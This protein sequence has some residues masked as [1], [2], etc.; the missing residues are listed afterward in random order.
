M[1]AFLDSLWF[2]TVDLV[3]QVKNLLDGIFAPLNSLG[4][5]IAI[6]AI[7]LITVL[8]AKCLSKTIK[9]RRYKELGEQF[10]YW[11]NLR[12]EALKNEDP[13]KAK[14]LAKNIDQAKLNR[15]YY[16]YFFEGLMISLVTKV[17]PVLVFLAYVNEAYKP[18]NLL[19]LFGREYVLR[20]KAS[21]GSEILVGAASW[22]VV[23]ILG[24][25]V[26][27]FI[28]KRMYLRYKTAKK[29]KLENEQASSPA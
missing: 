25:Y 20:F 15:A 24:V 11:F 10:F 12:Q 6:L 3:Y 21:G 13:D 9:T 16:D 29:T 5:V 8:I 28:A 1:E 7:A 19:K 4:P 18:S 27:W 2:K 23:S 17:L 14:R 22:F 26:L